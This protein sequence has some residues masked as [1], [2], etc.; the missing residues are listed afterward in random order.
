MSHEIRTPINAIQGMISLLDGS[1]LSTYQQQHINNAYDASKTLLYLVDELLD[2]AKIEAGKMSIIK[3]SCSLD[4]I[5]NNAIKINIGMARSKRLK[6]LVDIEPNVPITIL[7]DEMRLIQVLTN[8][9]N[10]SLKFTHE[11][12]VTLTIS[13]VLK[14][15]KQA[16]IT[17]KIN[18]TGIGISKNKQKHLFEAFRQVDESMTRQYGGSGLGL[19]I[20]QQIVNL[21]GGNIELISESG[22]GSEFNFTLPIIVEKQ[23]FESQLADVNIF[24]KRDFFPK[25]LIESTKEFGWHVNELTT[26]EA[27]KGENNKHIVLVITENFFADSDVNH[28]NGSVNLLVVCQ[29]LTSSALNLEDK[30]KKLAM[31]YIFWQ[32]ACYRQLLL[33]IDNV[34]GPHQES[35]SILGINDP[36]KCHPQNLEGVNILLVEDN[37]VN[38]LVA[39]EL[40]NNLKATVTIAEHG[41]IALDILKKQTFDVIL[42]DIQMP[43][44]DGLTATRLI[45]KQKKYA[46]LPII[47]MTAHARKEDRDNSIAAG[48]NIHMA[49]PVQAKV[50]LKTILTLIAKD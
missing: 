41:Q 40:L 42:M 1:V 45:R 27:I 30:L 46:Q 31:P 38:Q 23:C 39:K 20:C 21:L 43:V 19:S 25:N 26:V 49:K 16:D 2:S 37:L 9:L 33:D 14:E 3:E 29:P 5:I 48:I 36:T 44:M 28:L 35:S 12:E 24:C 32:Q 17:F 6:L 8:L 50:L 47:A 18:D 15:D 10:N 22:Q 13:A 4:S 11:G 7:T 34:M